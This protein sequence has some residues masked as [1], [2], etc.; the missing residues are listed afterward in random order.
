[1]VNKGN[2]EDY[3][4]QY[5]VLFNELANRGYES[6]DELDEIYKPL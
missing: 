4:I 6:D 5:D 2:L 1:M 3:P